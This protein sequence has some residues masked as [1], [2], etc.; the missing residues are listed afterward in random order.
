MRESIIFLN[1]LAVHCRNGTAEAIYPREGRDGL[2]IP[3]RLGWGLI[4]VA[5]GFLWWLVTWVRGWERESFREVGG[6]VSS[7]VSDADFELRGLGFL[8]WVGL[9]S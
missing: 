8:R 5:D 9:V 1:E 4:I 3:R 2:W 6:G 7:R